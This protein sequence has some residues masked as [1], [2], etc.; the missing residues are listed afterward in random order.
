MEQ[1][2]TTDGRPLTAADQTTTD[3]RPPIAADQATTNGAW[4]T[5]TDQLPLDDQ[6]STVGGQPSSSESGIVR[7]AIAALLWGI[8]R[9]TP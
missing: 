2:T 9:M 5:P 7:A 6:R 1:Q 3:G 4:S 8:M